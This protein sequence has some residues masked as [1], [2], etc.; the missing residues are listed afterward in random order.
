[1]KRIA[2]VLLVLAGAARAEVSTPK[3]ECFAAM[4]ANVARYAWDRAAE[5]LA[6]PGERFM[7]DLRACDST[8]AANIEEAVRYSIQSKEMAN[9]ARNQTAVLAA[10]GVAWGLVALAALGAWLRWRRVTRLLDELEA[11][12]KR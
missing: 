7:A 3:A 2:F 8:L 4:G 11:K 9:F 6:Q 5:T 10:Y 1:M 12:V